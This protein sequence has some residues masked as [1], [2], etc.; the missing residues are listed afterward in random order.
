M[1]TRK[2]GSQGLAVSSIGLGCMP[3]PSVATGLQEAQTIALL[4]RA[5]ELG[6][7]LFDTAEAYGPF[8]NEIQ[9][10]KA[11][12]PFRDR[13]VITTK[14]GYNIPPDG[15][16]PF[17]L[18]SH[19]DRIRAVCDAS[20][21]RLGIE[22]IDMFYQHKV[23][24]NVPIEDVAGTVSELIAAGKVRFFGLCEA[25]ADTIRRAHKIHPISAVQSEYSL[26]TRDPEAAVL[27]TCRAL[28]IGFVPYSPLGR[29]FLAGVGTD[30]SQLAENDFRRSMP[31]WQG[32]ALAANRVLAETLAALAAEKGRTAAQLAIAWLLHQGGNIV[33]IPGTTKIH[34]LEEN[35]AAADIHL[36]AD[37]LAAIEGAI[38]K[39]AVVGGRY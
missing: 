29:G 4:A 25:D 33:P 26:W 11:L 37:D 12:K 28:N 3:S 2:L 27:P 10:G 5:V 35:L 20:L 19:P 22:T 1:Q 31:R 18:D 24:P 6:A 13:V 23:D 14:F 9:V 7:T 39:T 34:R 36:S 8:E 16:R 21:Q 38:P 15:K 32:E 30:L 17:G